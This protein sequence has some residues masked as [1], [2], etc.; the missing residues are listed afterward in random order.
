[1]EEEEGGGV[2][3][4]GGFTFYTFFFVGPNLSHEAKK[5]YK[6]YYPNLLPPNLWKLARRMV[7]LDLFILRN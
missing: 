4:D 7:R 1:M 5:V 2:R 3:G 6:C